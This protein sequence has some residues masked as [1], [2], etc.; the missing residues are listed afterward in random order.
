MKFTS[1]IKTFFYGVCLGISLLPPGFSTATMAMILGIYEALINLLNDVF[2]SKVKS[3]LKTLVL[4]GVGALSAIFLFSWVISTTMNSFPLQTMSFFLG[5]I[6]ATVP[7]LYKQADVKSNFKGKHF[8]FMLVAFGVTLIFI[9]YQ[10]M[11]V[12]DLDGGMTF[13]KVIF[14]IFVG[15]LVSSSMI[16]PGLSGALILMLLGVYRFFMDSI[17]ALDFAVL[18]SVMLGGI[19]GLVLCGKLVKYLIVNHEITMSAV[20]MGLVLGSI[21]VVVVREILNADA[22][23]GLLG[24]VVAVLLGIVGFGLVHVLSSKPKPSQES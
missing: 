24:I 17:G 6:V 9:F 7:L 8:V 5:L 23:N 18:G 21:P 22:S 20:S 4:L 11:S 16:L 19:L 15:M 10:N 14:L 3:T 12:I 1:N 13:G 2:S